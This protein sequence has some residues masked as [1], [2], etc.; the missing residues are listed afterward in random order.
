MKLDRRQVVFG[1]T[2]CLAANAVPAAHANTARLEDPRPGSTSKLTIVRETRG[3][4][5][6]PRKICDIET[7]YFP[8]KKGGV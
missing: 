1:A 4:L 8:M 5:A 6:E 7:V 2:G 3:N